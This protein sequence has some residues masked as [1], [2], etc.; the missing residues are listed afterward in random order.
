MPDRARNPEHGS[1]PRCGRDDAGFAFA[2]LASRDPS[3]PASVRG[4]AEDVT[5][6]GIV[7]GEAGRG[8]T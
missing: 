1:S 8:E 7:E 4:A 3:A 5:A 6:A 2:A